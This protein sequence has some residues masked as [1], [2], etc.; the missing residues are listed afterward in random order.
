MHWKGVASIPFAFPR[1]GT[2][3]CRISAERIQGNF[4]QVVD[5]IGEGEGQGSVWTGDEYCA[6]WDERE[7]SRGAGSICGFCISARLSIQSSDDITG[8]VKY[9]RLYH[10]PRLPAPNASASASRAAIRCRLEE[11]G[12]DILPPFPR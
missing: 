11:L 2:S 1:S 7:E 5:A 3:E 4:T 12:K 10:R 8:Q 6:E 9:M